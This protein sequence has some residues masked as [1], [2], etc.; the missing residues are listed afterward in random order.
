MNAFR[1]CLVTT[2]YSDR[3]FLGS[4]GAKN[5]WQNRFASR[6]GVTS[7]VARALQTSRVA[8]ACQTFVRAQSSIRTPHATMSAPTPP[9]R[10]PA[11]ADEDPPPRPIAVRIK[12]THAVSNHVSTDHLTHHREVS[13]L[14]D[15]SD[16]LGDVKSRFADAEGIP[17]EQ[18][19]FLWFDQTI[20][21]R[22][23]LDESPKA[24]E[25]ENSSL[26]KLNIMF[27][28]AKFPHWSLVATFVEDPPM[29]MLERVHRTVAVV[30]KGMKSNSSKLD[31]YINT[32]RKQTGWNTL[33][34]GA[35]TPHDERYPE[36]LSQ[37]K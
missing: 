10:A 15:G 28:L 34:Y 11:T 14:D 22:H 29:D 19:R 33:V 17:V 21:K 13:I 2:F 25:Q 8:Y 16:T 24:M 27:W 6:R 18:V 23:V 7:E 12:V 9:A 31:R 35:P 26:Q 30:N 5:F 37:D 32:K 4:F 36:T 20:G 1:I 3:E